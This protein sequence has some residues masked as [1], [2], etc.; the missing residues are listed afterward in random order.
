MAILVLQSSKEWKKSRTENR[1][2]R[3]EHST[4]KAAG[5]EATLAAIHE[6]EQ[7]LSLEAHQLALEQFLLAAEKASR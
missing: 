5:A 4:L 3:A 7:R 6:R 1:H 2:L